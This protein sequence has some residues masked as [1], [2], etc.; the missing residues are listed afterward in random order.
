MIVD[1]E[2]FDAL[3][4]AV[5]NS[6]VRLANTFMVKVLAQLLD[7]VEEM[8]AKVEQMYEFLSSDEEE[9]NTT[10]EDAVIAE[11]EAMPVKSSAK[12]K[13][14]PKVPEENTTELES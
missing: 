7:T 1:E 11:E 2:D 5:D 10:K 6:Q 12:T 13:Q 9:T 8:H 4:E 3:V 14:A